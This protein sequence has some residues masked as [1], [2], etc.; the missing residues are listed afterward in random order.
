[1]ALVMTGT[2][3]RAHLEKMTGAILLSS[4]EHGKKTLAFR[5]PYKMVGKVGDVDYRVEIEPGKVKT[6]H[7]NMLK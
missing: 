5:G 4:T 1:M 2:P 7:I 3:R 6:Y